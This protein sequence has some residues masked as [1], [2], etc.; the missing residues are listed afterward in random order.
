MLLRVFTASKT[1]KTK[2]P[3]NSLQINQMCLSIYLFKTHIFLDKKSS[4]KACLSSNLRFNNKEGR[5]IVHL[6]VKA[7]K[8][9]A[10]GIDNATSK[11]TISAKAVALI[12]LYIAV[13]SKLRINP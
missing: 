3:F 6:E 4:L 7:P 5:Y 2:S 13:Q 12:G 1:S 11:V 10:A 9:L 8:V